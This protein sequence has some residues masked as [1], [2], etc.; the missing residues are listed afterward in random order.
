MPITNEA[1]PI[2]ECL[3]S[4]EGNVGAGGKDGSTML[5]PIMMSDYLKEYVTSPIGGGTRGMLCFP[6]TLQVFGD[7]VHGGDTIVK[8][9]LRMG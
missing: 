7:N 2:R 9:P 5:S 8:L 3:R 4:L 1:I 6:F